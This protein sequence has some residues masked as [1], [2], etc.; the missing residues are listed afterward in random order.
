MNPLL[1]S[2]LSQYFCFGALGGLTALHI[3]DG[4]SQLIAGGVF[5]GIIFAIIGS[6]FIAAFLRETNYEAHAR[7]GF[8]G[9]WEATNT[10]FLMLIPFTTLALIA[11]L[12]LDWNAVQ[13]FASAGIMTAGATMGI[14]LGKISKSGVFAGLMPS[15]AA[16]SMS[17]MW[18]VLGILAGALLA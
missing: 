4:N 5:A 6:F 9:I 12:A 3:S 14:E 15:A 10:G 16:L 1:S 7:R 2:G 18:M 11:E 17:V 13:V 8:A